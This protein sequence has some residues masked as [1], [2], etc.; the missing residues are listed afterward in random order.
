[1]RIARIVLEELLSITQAVKDRRI[2]AERRIDPDL[3]AVDF[4]PN[5]E[6]FGFP[7][8]VRRR[9]DV[10]NIVCPG[11]DLFAPTRFLRG[12]GENQFPPRQNRC[13]PDRI[14]TWGQ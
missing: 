7:L 9:L 4:F 1:M 8:P 6:R 12:L 3:V 10:E 14:G 11:Q 13:R 2:D 5:V